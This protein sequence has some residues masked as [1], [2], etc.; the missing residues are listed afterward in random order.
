MRTYDEMKFLSTE[1][2]KV[3]V[4]ERGVFIK[5]EY[6]TFYKIQEFDKVHFSFMYDSL[7]D[8]FL[9]TSTSEI[10][11]YSTPN[12]LPNLFCNP[13]C[14]KI[15]M[16]DPNNNDDNY[17][18]CQIEVHLNDSITSEEDYFLKSTHLD[19]NIIFLNIFYNEL[20][21]NNIDYTFNLF[22]V[23]GLFV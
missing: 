13:R 6:Q 14:R 15:V 8:Y 1:I 16:D 21:K 5:E 12:N 11:K 22:G 3:L 20:E 9:K 2:I 4:K 18:E 7:N 17:I 19:E 10:F 23:N